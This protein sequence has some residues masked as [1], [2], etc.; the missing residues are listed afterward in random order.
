ARYGSMHIGHSLERRSNMLGKR[1]LLVSLVGPIILALPN[2]TAG[3]FSGLNFADPYGTPAVQGEPSQPASSILFTDTFDNMK[4]TA[5]G[6]KGQC[7][8][9]RYPFPDAQPYFHAIPPALSGG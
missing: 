1:H 8:N 4:D 7:W 3:D 5:P 9:P 2:L 6:V